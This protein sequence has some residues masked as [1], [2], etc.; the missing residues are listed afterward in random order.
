MSHDR[1]HMKKPGAS[2][3]TNALPPR[4]AAASPFLLAELAVERGMAWADLA[5]LAGV[6]VSALRKWR[7]EQLYETRGWVPLV[8]PAA[9]GNVFREVAIP[10]FEEEQPPAVM[11]TQ[12]PCSMR[13]GAVLRP[14][15]TV[16]AVRKH[17][18]F[19]N[20]D[21]Q[22]Y[23]SAGPAAGPPAANGTRAPPACSRPGCSWPGRRRSRPARR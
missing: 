18:K 8:R 5:R 16:A 10:G 6:S 7:E 19:S 22:G 2:I 3:S 21:W 13:T 4:P 11:I 9:Q 14:R 15:L 12:H 17:A 23:A 1:L 20:A